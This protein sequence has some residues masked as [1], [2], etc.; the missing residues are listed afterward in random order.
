MLRPVH[1]LFDTIRH[2]IPLA[3]LLGVA[4]AGCATDDEAGREVTYS[5][6][7]KQNYDKGLAELK[8]ENY[9]EADKYF[10]FVKSKF[11]FS[12]Y[13]VL[14]ELAMA[15]GRFKRAEYQSAID[16]Y[17]AFLR[18]HPTHE[19]VEDGYV[20]F[21]IAQSYVRDMPEDWL[22]MPPSYEKDQSAVRDALRELSD[23]LDKYPDSKYV[24]TATKD[25]REVVR[26]LVEHE[27]YVARFYLD[28]G[29]PKAAILRLRG[30]VER[31]PDSGREA[32]LLLTMGET[33]LE[34]GNARSA[35][36]TFERV[37]ENYKGEAP[38][39]RAEVYL[40][41]IRNRFGQDPK[42]APKQA[43]TDKA[44]NVPNE[45]QG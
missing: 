33:H 15:D 11:P 37:R 28:Q 45:E 34:M 7:A 24:E 18:L 32:E 39:R 13:A 42:D 36:E 6:T 43:P 22:I 20:A 21:Q 17:K 12:K 2:G 40:D 41:F 27:V 16:S 3:L 19:K 9:I 29:H 30:A 8:D 14:A 5:V 1:R 26:R 44:G 35:R 10:R 23:F 31:Y 4:A 38:A 25:R